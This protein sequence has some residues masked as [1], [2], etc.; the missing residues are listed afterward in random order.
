MPITGPCAITTCKKES[1]TRWKRVTK[2]I[3]NK[4]QANNTL[5]SYL[6]IGDTI[7]LTCYNT[8]VVNSSTPSQQTQTDLQTQATIGLTETSETNEAQSTTN[9]SF[10]ESIEILTDLLYNREN[11]EGR[12]TIY[13]FDE[14]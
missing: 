1:S 5:P 6:Q 8:V 2:H 14:F 12:Q 10:T 3:I 7:C 11:K 4:G 13:S 9:L